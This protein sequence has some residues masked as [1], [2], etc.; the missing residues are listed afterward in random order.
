MIIPAMMVRGESDAGA[1]VLVTAGVTDVPGDTG[2]AGRTGVI[3]DVG[4]VIPGWPKLPA[5]VVGNGVG[6]CGGITWMV[7]WYE[8]FIVA[9]VRITG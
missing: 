5:P 1:V 3:A 4:P 2:L 6:V 9:L 8:L 7:V